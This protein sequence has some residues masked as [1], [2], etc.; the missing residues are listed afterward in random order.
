M[1][2]TLPLLAALLLA[3]PAAAQTTPAKPLSLEHRMLL[4]C[5]AAFAIVAKRQEAGDGQAK[6]WP[7][8][9]G[10]ASAGDGVDAG[11]IGTAEHPE[12]GTQVT[13]NG[14]PLYYFAGDSAPGDTNGQGQG[15]VWYVIDA[16][17]NPI[18]SD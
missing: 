16:T 17:G 11:L 5:S 7:P 1:T 3:A 13:Y 12:S 15:G 4:R 14:W 9:T 2:R 6:A 8:L 10:E 18:D